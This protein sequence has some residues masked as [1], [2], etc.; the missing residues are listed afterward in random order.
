[1]IA[2]QSESHAFAAQM[3]FVALH[4]AWYGR[5]ICGE[6]LLAPEKDACKVGAEGCD[7]E[8]VQAMGEAVRPENLA[9]QI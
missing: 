3:V 5:W 4:V 9:H 8:E 7:D 2:S 1:M 6:Y